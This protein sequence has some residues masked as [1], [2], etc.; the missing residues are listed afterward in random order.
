MYILLQFLQI[1]M[2]KVV[3][4]FPCWRQRLIT[5]ILNATATKY[6]VMQGARTSAAMINWLFPEYYLTAGNS[7]SIPAAITGKCLIWSG[8]ARLDKSNRQNHEKST[9]L[10]TELFWEYIKIYDGIYNCTVSTGNWNPSP[11]KTRVHL[12]CIVNPVA[13]DDLAKQGAMIII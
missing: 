9:L 13:D 3:E 5:H 8:A 11:W 2:S 7:V 12:F 10:H 4:I 6:L 1:E